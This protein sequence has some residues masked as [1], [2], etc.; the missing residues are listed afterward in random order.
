MDDGIDVSVKCGEKKIIL[1]T[2]SKIIVQSL[3]GSIPTACM[4]SDREV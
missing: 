4:S 3:M 1:N 2:K